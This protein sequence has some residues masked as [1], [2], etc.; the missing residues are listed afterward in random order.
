[1][2]SLNFA[3]YIFS[4]KDAGERIWLKIHKGAGE[5]D[6]SFTYPFNEPRDCVKTIGDEYF[7]GLSVG[8]NSNLNFLVYGVELGVGPQKIGPSFFRV[9]R[10]VELGPGKQAYVP[11]IYPDGEEAGILATVASPVEL[12]IYD[13][14]GNVT[15]LVGGVIQEL[16]PSSIYDSESKTAVIFCSSG[17]YCYEVVGTNEGNYGLNITSVS[18]GEEIT[19]EATNLPT[20]DGAVH[21]YTID[22]NAISA[23]EEGVILNIDR[24]G[25]G[26]FEQMAI[27]DNELSYDEFALQTE[28]VVDFDPDTLNLQSEGNFVTVYIELPE[29]FEVSEIDLFSL[30]LNE[31]VPP[32][33]KPIEIG[34]YDSDGINDLMVKFD[35]QELIEVLEPGEQIIDLTGRLWDGKPIAGFDFIRVIH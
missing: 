21:R 24:N 10:T 1:M 32:L 2:D 15:G 9:S 13:S 19:F 16:I 26:F 31:L 18:D 33:P 6:V 3:L 22:W 27:A 12:R 23:G 34:D 20:S 8:P 28:T 4:I 29:D 14:E 35:L 11:S 7:E 17:F 25:D 5:E 30:E